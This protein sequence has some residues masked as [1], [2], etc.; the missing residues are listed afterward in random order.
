MSIKNSAIDFSDMSGGKNSAFP[1]HALAEDQVADTLNLLHEA[2]GVSRAP[3]YLGIQST[4]FFDSTCEGQFT[5]KKDD[6]TEVMICVSNKRVYSVNP[7]ASSK[8]QIGTLTSAGK[9]YA[10][11][12]GGKLW[13]V[14]GVDFVK[15]ENDLNVY[16]V[17]IA[18]PA[19]GTATPKAGGTLADGVSGCYVAYARKNAAGQ[20]LYSM[21]FSLGNVTLGTGNNTITIAAPDSTDPQVT[22][23]VAFLTDAG[24]A[25]PYYYGEAANSV[26]SFDISSAANRNAGSTGFL[27]TVSAAN[28]ILPITPNA[29]ATFDDKIFVW[30]IGGRNIYWSL[31][32]DVNPFDMERFLAENFRSLSYTIDSIFSIG[33]DLFFN[34]IG[35]GVSVA[36]SGDMSSV[37]KFVQR[38]LWYLDCDT[39]EGKSNVILYKGTAFGLTNDGF[40]FFDGQQFSNDV[41]FHIKPD[42]DHI[43]AG[44]SGATPN[45]IIYRRPGKRTE[46]RFCY[47]NIDYGVQGNNDQRIFNMDFY[48]SQQ[49]QMTPQGMVSGNRKETWECWENGFAGMVILNG[50]WYG[51]QNGAAD[52]QIV[53]ENSVVDLYCYDRTGAFL[54]TEFLKQ[55]YGLTR[56]FIDDLDAISVWGAVYTL[57]TYGGIINGNV[58]LFDA[59]NSKFPFSFTGIATKQAI[60]PSEASGQGLE[61]PF[62]MNPQFPV[63]S[64]DPGVWDARGNSVAIEFSQTDKDESFFIYK[65]QLPRVKQIKNNLT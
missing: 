62:T 42:V 48:F 9:C 43:Y 50:A 6:G 17:Q 54:A 40:R 51:F 31:K 7:L 1:C 34:H 60:L 32:T 57:A 24:G 37:I 38:D 41:S 18:A 11:N 20:Y 14:N 47:R 26:A 58:I 55:A 39:P 27:S 23:K 12:A 3:G 63:S 21:P 61:I 2:I 28:Q 35:N 64:N 19:S 36:L 30:D 33:V 49:M 15:V 10:I 4:A 29:I 65:I 53:S 45:A 5:Y 59:G 8:T 44:I 13:I 52:A 46:Y 16:R 25:V 22:H 56:T